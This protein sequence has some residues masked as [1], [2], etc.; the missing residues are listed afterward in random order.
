VGTGPTPHLLDISKRSLNKH[1]H[2]TQCLDKQAR[3]SIE[4]NNSPAR[5]AHMVCI[6]EQNEKV[7]FTCRQQHFRKWSI[8]ISTP[9]QT[10]L[11]KASRL[12]RASEAITRVKFPRIKAAN[13]TTAYYTILKC[14]YNIHIHLFSLW[15]FCIGVRS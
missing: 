2:R 1:Y 5:G 10:P 13:A 4:V 3:C 8:I 9:V 6:Q 15:I 14:T 7:K 11:D 12:M